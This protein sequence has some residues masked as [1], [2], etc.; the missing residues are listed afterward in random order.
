MKYFLVYFITFSVFA[1][2][3][4]DY[5][6]RF[7]DKAESVLAYSLYWSIDEME[8]DN[9]S[10]GLEEFFEVDRSVLVAG[11]EYRYAF[12]DKF[13]A[14]FS[15]HAEI[16]DFETHLENE[17]DEETPEE[18][19]F[20][21]YDPAIELRYRVIDKDEVFFDVNTKVVWGATN[22]G[23]TPLSRTVSPFDGQEFYQISAIAGIDFNTFYLMAHVGAIFYNGGVNQ[24]EFGNENLKAEDSHQVDIG[25]QGQIDLSKLFKASLGMSFLSADTFSL[26]GESQRVNVEKSTQQNYFLKFDYLKYEERIG[27]L[28]FKVN[29]RIDRYDLQVDNS[30]LYVADNSYLDFIIQVEKWF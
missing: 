30:D 12:T 10:T 21:I 14:A 17:L 9:R 13:L 19:P 18:S 24:F 3:R 11:L 5:L 16:F 28:T 27:I 23:K 15:T 22:S 4:L 20:A 8:F 25:F 6:Y 29:Q 26:T 2:N 7:P 1:V